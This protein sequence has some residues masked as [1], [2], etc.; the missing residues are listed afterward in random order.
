[1][2]RI[3][4]IVLFPGLFFRF[5]FHLRVVGGGFGFA[6][7]AGA[8]GVFE[9]EFELARRGGGFEGLGGEEEGGAEALG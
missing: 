5:L 2:C 3:G 8:L 6:L 4:R 9:L 1:M 7:Q